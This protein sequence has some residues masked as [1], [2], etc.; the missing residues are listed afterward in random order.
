MSSATANPIPPKGVATVPGAMA[1]PAPEPAPAVPTF[2][3]GLAQNVF[4][5]ATADWI[6]GEVWVES[7]FDSD[8]DGKLDRMHADYTLPKETATDGLKVPVIYEDS[9]YYAGTAPNYSQLER[10]PRARR[11]AARR[12]RSRRS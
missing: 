6:S 11:A 1:A 12:A 7:D 2:V 3:N 5:A 9:P 8:G 10:R 4:S